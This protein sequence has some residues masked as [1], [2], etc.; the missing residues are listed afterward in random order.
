MA[1]NCNHHK[2][3]KQIPYIACYVINEMYVSWLTEHLSLG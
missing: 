1:S 2:T 3:I